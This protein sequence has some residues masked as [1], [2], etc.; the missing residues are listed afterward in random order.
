MVSTLPLIPENSTGWH[1]PGLDL[2][3]D[4][5]RS[6][7]RAFVSHAHSDHFARHR[8]ILC[9]IP[10]AD[11]LAAR[12]RQAA[13][14]LDPRPF[15]Q[16]WEE[17]GHRLELLPAGH[18]LGSAMLHVTR[19]S[20]GASMLYTGDFKLRPSL[21]AEPAQ[22]KA[23]GLLLTE[24]TFGRPS[25]VFPRADGLWERV[26][27]FALD[28]L[29]E[30]HVPV[31]VGYSLGKATEILARIQPLG[32]PVLAHPSI[33]EMDDVVRRHCPAPLPEARPFTKD[34]DPTGHILV[35]PPNAVRSLAVRRLRRK[36]VLVLTGWALDPAA[37]FRY[38]CDEALPISDHADYPELLETI[39]R[40]QPARVVV[41]HGFEAEFS[42]DLRARGHDAWSGRGTDQL[43]L[44]ESNAEHADTEGVVPSAE[45]TTHGGTFA[46]WAA[47]GEMVAQA[48]G[49]KARV[50][51]L[52]ELLRDLPAGDLPHAARFIAGKPL[53][54]L[55]GQLQFGSATLRRALLA[56]TGLPEVRY[57]AISATQRDL[58]RT[59]AILLQEKS[60]DRTVSLLSI[61]EIAT[62]LETWSRLTGP[63]SRQL[64][65]AQTLKD[66][67]SLEGAW[68]VRLLSGQIRAGIQT[69]LLE[70]AIAVAFDAE[71][72]AVRR[73]HML[74]GDAGDTADLARRRL[75]DEAGLVPF[76][77]V[78]AMLAS[79]EP[80]AASVHQRLGGGEIWLEDKFDGIRAQ[81][82]HADGRAALYSRDLRDIS[83][84]FPEILAAA[85][86]L[87]TGVV[88]DGEII[89]RAEGRRLGFRDLQK[90]LGRKVQQGDLFHGATV[91]VRFLAFDCLWC[92][93]QSLI[94]KPLIER[95]AVLESLVW[96]PGLEL[97]AVSRAGDPAAIDRLFTE[98]RA[99]GN[100][101]L[102]AKNPNTPYTPG[103]RGKSWI[104]LKMG[105]ITLDVVVV[106][107]EQGHG[108]R[109]H[110]LSDYT[111]A[112]R[113]TESGE[114]S[115]IGKA[116]SGLTDLEI[117]ELTAHFESQ[118]TGR[119]GRARVVVPDTVLEVACDRLQP[120]KRHPSGLAMRFP[121]I[122]A[123]RRDKSPAEADTL[124]TARA[125]AGLV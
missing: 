2:W 99:R 32:L 63:D 71:P 112:V 21:T 101:G 3:L 13:A 86:L 35:I 66:I 12:Y 122:K 23:A 58:G 16:P 106:R 56:A 7:G 116:Y 125:L 65:L 124:A 82:H 27:A 108:K 94:D 68:L 22:L 15:S 81:L 80:D 75:L 30:N 114:W 93:G 29:E 88:L 20:D 39:A 100:E 79:P 4:P 87:P 37:R 85:Q 11:L 123:I 57:R 111:F 26:R 42:R 60:T 61:G 103:R 9:S 14:S 64:A 104:K 50:N 76:V 46:R 55:T 78:Q 77:P 72:E 10:T 28:A 25:Y 6:R 24:C 36:R 31:L 118:T 107:A 40:V 5:H 95:R 48:P 33:L 8:S 43:E 59:A 54:S 47:T 120:S 119:A 18:I 38:Q 96:P 34:T 117:E 45:P 115:I 1:L 105:E 74:T 109:A 121:R 62:R 69:G 19:L 17:S 110:V 90:R 70:E 91:P 53:G 97:V 92:D 41:T 73:A 84:E 102:M 98:A 83:S 89:A 113:D 49:N 51:A 44:F 67:S 52:A